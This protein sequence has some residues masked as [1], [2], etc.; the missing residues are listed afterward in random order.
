MFVV[1]HSAGGH[2]ASL[3]AMDG[4]ILRRNGVDPDA[5][6]GFVSIDGI[7][8]LGAS[9]AAFKRKQADVVR[10]L[11]GPDDASLAAHSTISY[12]RAPPAT[13]IRR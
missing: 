8:D 6:S 1:G 2:L 10:Q 7:F 5:I 9:L 3:L 12:A 13:A 11:F 4:R